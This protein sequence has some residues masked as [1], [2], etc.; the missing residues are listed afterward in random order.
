MATNIDELVVRIKADTASLQKA[1]AKTKKQTNQT[2][3]SFG[4]LSGAIKAIKGPA[5]ALAVSLAAIGAVVLPIARVGMEFEN[6][7]LSLNTVFGSI[8]QGESAFRRVKQFATESPFQ[9]KDLTKAFIQLRSAGIE[10]SE[11]MFKTFAD[12]ASVTIDSL[13][14]FEALVRITQRS[15]G[16]GLGLEELNQISDRG[17]PVFE[18]LRQKLG[19]TRLEITEMGVTAEGAAKI[20]NALNEGLSERFGGAVD[21][22]METL[23]Q[24]ISNMNDAFSGLADTIFTELGV[25]AALKF[26][27]E[28]MGSAAKEVDDFFMRMATGKSQAQLDANNI[29][30]EQIALDVANKEDQNLINAI[31]QETFFGISTG[32]NRDNRAEKDAIRK[33]IEDRNNQILALEE[34]FKKEQ[35]EIAKQKRNKDEAEAEATENARLKA[36]K[37]A[38]QKRREVLSSLAEGT[39]LPTDKLAAEIAEMQAI[40]EGGDAEKI[41][42]AFAGLAPQEVLDTLNNQLTEM[43]KK[44]TEAGTAAE[45]SAFAEE[46]GDI[47]SAIEGTINPADK[48]KNIIERIGVLSVEN[49]DALEE[50]LGGMKLS[51]VLK[52][53]NDDL[54]EL[55]TKAEDVSET[56]GSQLQQAV[57]NAANAFTTNFVNALMEGKSALSSFKDFAK[58]MVSQIISIFLQMAIVNEILNSVFKLSG[59]N[60]FPTLGE[61]SGSGGMSTQSAMDIVY[62]NAGGG[63]YQKGVPT[64]VGERGPELIIPNTGGRVMNNMN[65]KNAMGGGD[66]IVVNQSLNFSTGVVGTVRAEINKMMPT[67]AEVSKSAVLDASRRGG[68]YRKGL[69]GSA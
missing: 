48:L 57:T 69:L 9:I 37:D 3:K 41:K 44:I 56:L 10:P 7:K 13:G 20:M 39:I 15:A 6:L 45:E 46:F 12:A 61:K 17:I 58:N 52:I 19:A 60:A 27:A 35:D 23:T 31:D 65:T 51:E 49:P 30:Q 21:A 63:A 24:K 54:K 22:K 32:D 66:T 18:I 33:R 38:A 1:L 55:K 43:K 2:K 47:Q 62:G 29:R 40:F 26:I 53:L 11:K 50:M 14:A 28:G 36:I 8:R 16:G 67:I 25:G 59:S 64:L 42:E 4:G 68:N 34:E 5:K